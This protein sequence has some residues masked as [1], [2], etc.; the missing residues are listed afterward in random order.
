MFSQRLTYLLEKE[1][2][3][4]D[5]YTAPFCD[6][7]PTDKYLVPTPQALYARMLKESTIHWTRAQQLDHRLILLTTEGVMYR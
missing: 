5:H 2:Y 4:T 7:N 3:K 6:L 1:F